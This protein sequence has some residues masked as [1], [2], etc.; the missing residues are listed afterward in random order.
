MP[1]ILSHNNVA[2]KSIP[3]TSEAALGG[4]IEPESS[5]RSE[6]KSVAYKT[7]ET[8]Q[9]KSKSLMSKILTGC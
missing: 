1:T 2:V 7:R 9:H 8:V 4:C 6:L 3:C 5:Q